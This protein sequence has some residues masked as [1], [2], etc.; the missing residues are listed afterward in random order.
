MVTLIF[1]MLAKLKTHLQTRFPD[2]LQGKLLLA[3]SGGVDSVVMLHLLADLKL[4]IAVAHCNFRLREEQ[5]DQ[6]ASFVEALCLQRGIPF[7]GI[8]FDTEQY[9]EEKGVSIQ[10]A[11]RSLR[12]DWFEQLLNEQQL[13]FVLTAHHL[14]DAVETFLINFSRGTGL[15]GLTG[16]PEQNQRIVRPLLIFSREEIYQHAL[17]QAWEWR[18]DR[19]NAETKY[20]RNKL[21]KNVVPLLK[22]SNPGFLHAFKNSIS[23]LREANGMVKDA[24]ETHYKQVVTEVDEKCHIDIAELKTKAN[25]LAY[26]HFWLQPYGFKNWNDV[27]ALIEASTGKIIFS[28]SHLLLKNRSEL[29]LAPKSVLAAA[30]QVY[31]LDEN[32][33][34]TQPITLKNE[35]QTQ[36][37]PQDDTYTIYVDRDRLQFPLSLRKW[38]QGDSFYPLGMQGAKKISKYFKDEKY[39]QIDK[40]AA[41]ILCSENQIVWIVGGRMDD[42]FK[43]KNTTINIL[44]IQLIQ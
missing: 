29:I 28:D 24:S 26:L 9:A 21:R 23:F 7:F 17:A 6:D 33:T 43:I 5:S 41:W 2:L 37:L 1:K 12:Y 39:S 16:I 30:E 35:R 18:E 3:V 15:D 44:K 10:I 38:R 11:A 22:E 31:Y 14:D 40:E 25:Y 20:L 36:L 8:S 42:R 27:D 19:S 4:D 13:D 34:I 32:E